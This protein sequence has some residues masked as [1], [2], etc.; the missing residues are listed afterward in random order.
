MCY[1][2]FCYTDASPLDDLLLEL[3]PNSSTIA[4][5]LNST[6]LFNCTNNSNNNNNNNNNN[7]YYL[8]WTINHFS[9]PRQV[10]YEVTVYD[11]SS[12]LSINI[13]DNALNNSIITCGVLE[14][15]D[16][17]IVNNINTTI[18]IQGLNT[19]HTLTGENTYNMG[20]LNAIEY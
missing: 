14:G 11:T 19:I 7:N 12:T 15:I 2:S 10:D 17:N 9:S 4:V 13:T 3:T 20:P 8:Y 18:I 16:G 1:F 5:T 6:I